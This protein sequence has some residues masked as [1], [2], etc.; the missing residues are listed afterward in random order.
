[1]KSVHRGFVCS[2]LAL[3]VCTI[4]LAQP[5]HALESMQDHD[6]SE[7][8]GEGLALLP[9]N[10]GLRFNGA[11]TANGGRG[12]YDTGYIHFIPVGPISSAGTAAG[13]RKGDLYLY[14]LSLSQSNQGY[15]SI[16]TAADL[17][18]GY[19]QPI[20]RWGSQANPWLL[21]TRT[22]SNVPDFSGAMRDVPLLSMQAPRYET[23]IGSTQAD[24]SAYNLKLGMWSDLFAR[25]QTVA[26]GNAAQFGTVGPNNYNRL[27][28][29][30]VWD[31]FSINGSELNVFQTLGGATNTNGMSTD[32]NFTLGIS[33]LVRLNSGV[34]TGL[35]A[36]VGPAGTPVAGTQSATWS[37][38]M[39]GGGE[40]CTD[41]SNEQC[42]YR[43]RI[44]TTP[45]TSTNTW[46]A[47]ATLESVLYLG[48]REKS[49]SPNASN[50]LAT[51]ALN[52][53]A[54]P[55]FD[56]ASEGL[57]LYSP[58]INLVLGTRYQPL[59]LSSSGNNLV[60]EI[61]RI[62]NVPAIYQ[63]IYQ[64]YTNTGTPKV[65]NST[66]TGLGS[67]GSGDTTN[68][69]YGSTCSVHYCGNN[70]NSTYQGTN[71][72]HSSISI[73]TT[74]WD[75]TNRYLNAYKGVEAVGISLGVLP[76][77]GTGSVTK[78]YVSA[79]QQNY[80]SREGLSDYW[81]Y[82]TSASGNNP[83]D[84]DHS[85]AF[86]SNAYDGVYGCQA[87]AIACASTW[88]GGTAN[89]AK[90]NVAIPYYESKGNT[91]WYNVTNTNAKFNTIST[92]SAPIGKGSVAGNFGSAVID[93]LM[94]QHIKL[95][96]TGL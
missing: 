14:G 31:G 28:L 10:F 55:Q 21:L 37:K 64:K 82:H 33:G 56:P 2:Q 53:G 73:G 75:A 96:T 46:T 26:E 70:G 13:T 9:E 5:V 54:A 68:T 58:N 18:V 76:S 47:P 77:S 62:P 61:A 42:Q 6:L 72:T 23:T 67:A 35:K 71:A 81:R 8:T 95:T 65:D 39:E 32:Y 49:T 59:T 90:W 66:Y 17:E 27:R 20:D 79:I 88:D 60:M 22:E 25:D 43:E 29:S 34:S 36:T 84:P 92:P 44:K 48:T 19:G 57:F 89:N 38:P 1:M 3:A 50:L 94:I 51:P 87:F 40:N 16:R 85:G 30:A 93:G 83:N 45:Y 80:R 24:R 41:W 7:A 12:T 63:Q 91:M 15:N 78:D 52:G 74:E 86:G 11:D 69:Y 4:M